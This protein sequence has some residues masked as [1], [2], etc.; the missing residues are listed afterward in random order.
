MQR[1]LYYLKV[2]TLQKR[3]YFCEKIL[4]FQKLNIPVN[5]FNISG[6]GNLIFVEVLPSSYW[7]DIN[8]LRTSHDARR[9]TTTHRNR[10]PEWLRWP[11]KLVYIFVTLTIK[12]IINE[13]KSKFHC[14][15]NIARPDRSQN[16]VDTAKT[17]YLTRISIKTNK[18]YS[19]FSIIH[20]LE[21]I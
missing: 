3:R 13:I 11:K 12:K 19:N 4:N 21:K 18:Q 8:A 10:S 1:K 9:R 17:M 14:C 7:G 15:I 2:Q 6:H 5:S 20:T 16:S